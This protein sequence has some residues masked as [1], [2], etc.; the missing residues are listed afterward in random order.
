MSR[1]KV[2]AGSESSQPFIK[3]EW[4]TMDNM[5]FKCLSPTAV[6]LWLQ[7][8][9]QWRAEDGGDNGLKLPYALV[10]WKL[11]FRAFKLARQELLNFGFIRL[12]KQGGLLRNPNVY[13]IREDWKEK[14]KELAHDD[15]AGYYVWRQNT[16]T[17]KR[18]QVWYPKKRQRPKSRENAAIA[19]AAKK[20][21]SHRTKKAKPVKVRLKTSPVKS[22]TAEEKRIHVQDA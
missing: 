14:C 12:I 22:P 8:R 10:S 7:I 6:W 17:R 11:N 15:D 19:R 2:K 3:V 13:A 9:R 1:R 20:P 18:Y 16:K 5:A 21:K 4:A